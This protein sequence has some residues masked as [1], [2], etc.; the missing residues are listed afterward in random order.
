MCNVDLP[1]GVRL[2]PLKMHA[3][4][5]GWVMEIFRS[6][7][8][9]THPSRQWN[10]G[11]SGPNV[12][13]GAHVHLKHTDYLAVLDGRVS[14]GLFDLRPRSRAYRKSA[15]VELSDRRPAAVTLPH[16]VLHAIYSHEATMHVYGLDHYY[17]PGDDLACRWDDPALGIAWPCTDPVL[18][19]RDR[20][21]GSL[22]EIEATLRRMNVEFA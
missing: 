19:D 11:V 8:D 10:A 20:S 9:V 14:I 6:E 22:A 3:D 15:L 16:G 21:A 1:D 7:W 4:K 17:D 2:T 12:M 5:R 13:R 18:S